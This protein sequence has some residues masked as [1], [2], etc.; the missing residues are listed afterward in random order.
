MAFNLSKNNTPNMVSGMEDRRRRAIQWNKR[1]KFLLFMTIFMT[2]STITI[3]FLGFA[4]LPVNRNSFIAVTVISVL[5]YLTAG[6]YY[7]SYIKMLMEG[8]DDE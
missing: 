5:G 4:Y 3:M 2:I 1:R 7:D 8:G 6:C